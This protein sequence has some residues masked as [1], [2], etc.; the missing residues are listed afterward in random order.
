VFSFFGRGAPAS[1][2]QR[3][4]EVDEEASPAVERR[5]SSQGSGSGQGGGLSKGTWVRHAT[6]GRGR[7][8]SIEGSGEDKR[9]I[10]YFQGQG[11][12][13]LVAKYAKLEIC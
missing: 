12:R 11:R 4:V 13:K 8:L 10:V 7:I 5:G 6:L 2:S 3:V 1:G 9:L